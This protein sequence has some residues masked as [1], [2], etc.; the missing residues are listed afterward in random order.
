M[1]IPHVLRRF[2]NSPYKVAVL[3]GFTI[4]G[5]WSAF[6]PR[7]EGRVQ[8]AVSTALLAILIL[9]LAALLWVDAHTTRWGM[10]C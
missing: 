7:E 10:I 6:Q 2:P 1:I 4:Y 9:I 3:A 5:L 8:K